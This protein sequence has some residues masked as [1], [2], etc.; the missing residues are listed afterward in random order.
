[1]IQA[2]IVRTAPTLWFLGIFFFIDTIDGGGDVAKKGLVVVVSSRRRFGGKILVSKSRF[3][4]TVVA[5]VCHLEAQ[6]MVTG[7]RLLAH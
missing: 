5:N 3:Q 2:R 4:L 7:F 1:M 6:R